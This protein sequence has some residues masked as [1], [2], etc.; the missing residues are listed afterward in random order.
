MI[1]SADFLQDLTTQVFGQVGSHQEEAEC[2]ARHLVTAN[3]C[4]HD[5]HGVIR[6]PR[7]VEF[8]QNEQTLINQSITV[9]QDHGALVVVDGHFG[10]GQSI[11]E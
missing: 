4:G 1:L 3:L 9:E 11:G 6:I 8:L 5:S 10:L 7:Y 2:V